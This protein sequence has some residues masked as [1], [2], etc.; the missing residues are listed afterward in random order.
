MGE[1]ERIEAALE[2]AV[3][4]GG[5]DGDHHKAWVIDQMVRVLTGERYEALV[6]ETKAG[7]DGPETY[8]WNEGIAP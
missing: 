5:I 6:A 3:R 1:A 7:E 8:S 2:I 4:Y